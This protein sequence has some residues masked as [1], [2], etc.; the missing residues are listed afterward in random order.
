MLVQNVRHVPL[1]EAV[2]MTF[3]GS[4][5]CHICHAVAAGKK[6]EKK[7]QTFP[8]IA[9]VDLICPPRPRAWQP[10]FVPY[11]YRTVILQVAQRETVPPTPPPRF[12]LG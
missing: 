6:S 3:D 8:G 7:N 2:A 9:K 1:T 12:L 10:P 4:H 5:P 11:K